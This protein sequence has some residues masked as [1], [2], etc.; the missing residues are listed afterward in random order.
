MTYQYECLKCGYNFEAFRSILSRN[1]KKCPK[2][3]KNKLQRLIGSG[4]SII[5]KESIEHC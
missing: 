1:L 2:C 3:N 4:G 5:F